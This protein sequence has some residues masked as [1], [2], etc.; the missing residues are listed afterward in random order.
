MDDMAKSLNLKN[1]FDDIDGWA[2]VSD[3]QIKARNP[4][5]TIVIDDDTSFVR[6]G[7]RL[8]DALDSLYKKAYEN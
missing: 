8:I 7:P 5:I 2:E 1:I 3:E 6:P 4:E